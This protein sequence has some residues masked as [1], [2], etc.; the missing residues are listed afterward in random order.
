MSHKVG[1][2]RVAKF[3]KWTL[4]RLAREILRDQ[5]AGVDPEAKLAQLKEA[6]RQNP[7]RVA[8]AL[9]RLRRKYPGVSELF[10]DLYEDSKK[11]RRPIGA[12]DKRVR[13]TGIARRTF[14]A[15]RPLARKRD[16]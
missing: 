2:V 5:D 13:V 15:P 8:D 7:V 3:T 10:E 9:Y 1:V 12:V 16:V 4:P 11:R 6:Y 14:R